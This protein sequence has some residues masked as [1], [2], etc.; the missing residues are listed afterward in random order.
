[1]PRPYDYN[2]DMSFQNHPAIAQYH[3][4]LEALKSRGHV[5]ESQTRRVFGRL[6]EK[7]CDERSLL[8][9][10][11]FPVGKN[12]RKK[13]DGAVQDEYSSLGYWEAKDQA[14]DLETEIKNKIALGYLLSN[15]IFEDTRQA[16]LW[17]NQKQ[18]ARFDLSKSGDVSELLENFFS[19]NIF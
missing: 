5:S 13:V 2:L 3:T 4:N 7:I 17:Q 8:F 10:E 15:I 18:V 9:V 14:D 12:G 16:I 1:M 6:L 11:E 19:Q